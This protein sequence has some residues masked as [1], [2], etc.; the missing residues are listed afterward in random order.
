MAE[1]SGHS[2]VPSPP[3]SDPGD[4]RSGRESRCVD[5]RAGAKALV[6][7]PTA[8]VL[9][10]Q[11]RRDDGS[12]FWALPG[13]G[14][15]PGESLRTCLRRELREELGSRA[16][17]AAPLATCPYRHT[18]RT[19]TVSLYAVYGTLLE[20]PPV[21]RPAEGIVD[22]RWVSPADPPAGTLRPFRRLLSSIG[23]GHGSGLAG[24]TASHLRPRVGQND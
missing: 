17:V 19:D 12:T 3:A 15:R 9:L 21:P 14:C 23:A 7:S 18:S 4:A 2:A 8:A 13:G 20:T 6:V 16:T 5:V 1:R 24:A 10:V 22:A 11:E